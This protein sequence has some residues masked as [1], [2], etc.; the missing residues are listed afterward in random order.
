MAEGT[1]VGKAFIAI[2][3]D[4]S[5]ISRDMDGIKG[6]V[7]G[8]LKSF[9]GPIAAALSVTGFTAMIKDAAAFGDQMAK[10][11][12]KVGI[13]VEDLQRLRHV[14]GLSGV[15][16]QGMT[17][18][19]R[20]MAQ[21]AVESGKPLGSMTELLAKAADEFSKMEDGPIKTAKAVEMFGRAGLDMIPMLNQGSAAIRAQM[22]ELDALGA[23][24]STQTAKQSEML[25]DNISRLKT[26]LR[27]LG[28][29]IAE[30]VIPALADVTG[31]MVDW[32]K[33]NQAVTK[34]NITLFVDKLTV[35]FNALGTA[36]SSL[37]SIGGKSF[38]DFST[39]IRGAFLGINLFAAGTLK[40]IN[41]QLELFVKPLV[42]L[43]S[44]AKKMGGVGQDGFVD[45]IMN[46]VKNLRVAQKSFEVSAADIAHNWSSAMSVA[47]NLR[48]GEAAGESPFEQMG[49][50]IK[51]ATKELQAL[52]FEGNEFWSWYGQLLTGTGLPAMAG[53]GAGMAGTAGQ[54]LVPD[55]SG[56]VGQLQSIRS[57]FQTA[58]G[59]PSWSVTGFA[60][61]EDPGQAIGLMLFGVPSLGGA[62]Q[63]WIDS[64]NMVNAA[65]MESKLQSILDSVAAF[66]VTWGEVAQFA[67]DGISS[68]FSDAVVSGFGA[69]AKKLIAA[70]VGVFGQILSKMGIALIGEGIGAIIMGTN[71]FFP[72]PEMVAWGKMAIIK[73]AFLAAG[74]GLMSGV[75][76]VIGGTSSGSAGESFQSGI[77]R[78]VAPTVTPVEWATSS[79]AAAAA[80]GGGGD[81]SV[82]NVYINAVDTQSIKDAIYRGKDAVTGVVADDV[83]GNGM[84][85]QRLG[86]VFGA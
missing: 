86:L 1:Q 83:A 70:M 62:I 68:F 51:G 66:G 73:G 26:G 63:T 48:E 78:P 2:G 33:S 85:R 16:F 41:M 12:Q 40:I 20:Q 74:G 49:N 44:I 60:A 34:Q 80:G 55:I 81:K 10:T 15:S 24:M 31:K 54:E 14:A 17:T 82:T 42:L 35:S 6:T 52:N 84:L 19:M 64:V 65:P 13:S 56:I 23:V 71:P 50:G 37:T 7:L 27:G 11:S 22:G 58:L 30:A 25:N 39:V 43:N 18:A 67:G 32:W 75:S 4:G 38:L 29:T 57:Q 45:G 79:A 5:T 76:S 69:G 77:A 61:G 9:A 36:I 47:T 21:R 46:V 28:F 8:A 72:R 53:I 3:A 59:G